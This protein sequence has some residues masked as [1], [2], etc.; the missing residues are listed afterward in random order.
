METTNTPPKSFLIIGI[1]SLLWNLIGVLFYL[2]SAYMPDEVFQALPEIQQDFIL[3]TPAWATAAFA[4]AVF[5]GTLGSIGLLIKK[6]WAVLL[7]VLSLLG[8]L[9]NYI[10]SYAMSTGYEV[11]G[12]ATGMIMPVLV[13]VIGI[14][15]VYYSRKAKT[16]S[17]FS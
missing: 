12:G 8:I 14:F 9:S 16:N 7:F 11:A 10:Y 6:K 13:T 2:I 3:S 15:L 17:S 4:I 1:L 5:G